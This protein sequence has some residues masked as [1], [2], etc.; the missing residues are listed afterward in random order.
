[1]TAQAWPGNVRELMNRVERAAILAGPD[2]RMGAGLFAGAGAA[3]PLAAGQPPFSRERDPEA[4][5]AEE[6][7]WRARELLRLCGG[8]R[9]WASRL[10]GIPASR[11]AEMLEETA[12][13]S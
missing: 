1:L 13:G 10:L 6:E 12:A 9:K 8:D 7:R 3:L 5:L 4:W 11:L 2:G